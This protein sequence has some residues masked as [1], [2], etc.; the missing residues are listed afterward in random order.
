MAFLSHNHAHKK[1]TKQPYIDGKS[2]VIQLSR[3][4]STASAEWPRDVL[5]QL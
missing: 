4:R 1:P 3:Q 2:Q 5:C